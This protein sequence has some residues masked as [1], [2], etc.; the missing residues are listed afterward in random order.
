[1]EEGKNRI[2]GEFRSHWKKKSLFSL[3]ISEFPCINLNVGLEYRL[4]YSKLRFKSLD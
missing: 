3:R 2:S 1:M 4:E